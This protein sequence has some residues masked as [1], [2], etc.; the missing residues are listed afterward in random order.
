MRKIL[1]ILMLLFV[2]SGCSQ[3]GELIQASIDTFTTTIYGTATLQGN[4]YSSGIN[5]S[6]SKHMS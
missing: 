6:L 5:V 1:P 4:S 2:L 3:I